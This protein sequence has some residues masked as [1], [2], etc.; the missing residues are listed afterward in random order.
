MLSTTGTLDSELD[1]TDAVQ[2]GLAPVNGL[3]QW[4]AHLTLS[5]HQTK[6]VVSQQRRNVLVVTRKNMNERIVRTRTKFVASAK[7]RD[8]LKRLALE[9]LVVPLVPP[10]RSQYLFNGGISRVDFTCNPIPPN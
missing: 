6:T 1:Q 7:S 3:E 4:E 10:G 2:V 5:N 8:T 9:V